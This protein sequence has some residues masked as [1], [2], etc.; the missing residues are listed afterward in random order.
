LERVE[1]L[2]N[3][4]V[5]VSQV[6]EKQ[7]FSLEPRPHSNSQFRFS[8]SSIFHNFTLQFLRRPK[9][10]SVLT[11]HKKWLQDLQKTKEYLEVKYLEEI[12][13]K[14]TERKKFKLHEKKMREMQITLMK[15][16]DSK[17][18]GLLMMD[19]EAKSQP[20]MNQISDEKADSKTASDAKK[21]T[22]KAAS[23]R[24]AWALTEQ[25]AESS[26]DSKA[27]QEELDLL[28]FAKDLD[29]DKYMDDVEVQTTME[30]LRGRILELEKEVDTEV[31]LQTIRSIVC[32]P[33][34][35]YPSPHCAR[36]S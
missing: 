25:A 17:E 8:T 5:H 1:C 3:A 7:R 28:D 18:V 29:F 27:E 32:I 19:A 12:D 26:S 33:T 24:P 13:N 20:S 15:S 23:N 36:L 35:D 22:S 31:N 30:R 2:P 34:I 21:A 10:D 6:Q 11:K 16:G 9:K 4:C 14:D